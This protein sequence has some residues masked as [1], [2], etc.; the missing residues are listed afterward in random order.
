MGWCSVWGEGGMWRRKRGRSKTM[1]R[2]VPSQVVTAIGQLFPHV[3]SGVDFKLFQGSRPAVLALLDLIE[4][5]P[6]ELMPIDTHDVV[7]LVI[8]L[9]FL[10]GA[11]S[12]W[13]TSDL[14]FDRV[15]GGDRT[16]IYDIRDILERCPDAAPT[17]TTT[18]LVFIPEA[19]LRE[20]LRL[21]I[22]TAN[23]ALANGE[24]KAATV[25]AGSVVEAL[26]LWAIQQCPEA[27]YKAA[28]QEVITKK[29]VNHPRYK[30]LDQWD[31]VHYI[32]VAEELALI[33]TNTA[34]QARLAKDFRNLIHPG[35]A[36]RLA[37]TCTRGTTH[38][39]LAAMNL[40]IESVTVSQAQRG[41]QT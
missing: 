9:N 1:P 39:A 38:G 3:H 15:D 16:V 14:A 37:Q 18:E 41:Q 32:A 2:V 6:P 20:G 8:S 28:L 35:R 40:V 4:H 33:D 26:L 12:Q 19:D 29:K 31:L 17:P 21:D 34:T 24:W 10:R 7:Q 36:Q 11:L 25:L 13:A 23:Q 22:S 5:I 27:Q 30:A